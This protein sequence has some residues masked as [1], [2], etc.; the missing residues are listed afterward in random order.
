MSKIPFLII[1]LSGVLFLYPQLYGK[2]KAQELIIS[3]PQLTNQDSSGVQIEVN[4]L[5]PDKKYFVT[6]QKGSGQELIISG[7]RNET[8][9]SQGTISIHLCPSGL[10]GYLLQD[11]CDG[12]TFQENTYNVKAYESNLNGKRL[13][14]NSSFKVIVQIAGVIDFQN[15]SFK[16]TDDITI[17]VSGISDGSYNISVDGKDPNKGGAC[18]DA[19]NG[20][21]TTNIGKYYEGE[22]KIQVSTNPRSWIP[23]GCGAGSL[24][25]YRS[26]FINNSGLGGPGPGVG[27]G[28][29]FPGTDTIKQCK[30]RD[31][32]NFDKKND[33]VCALSGGESC[34]NNPTNPGFKTAIGCIH[35]NPA[36]LTKDLL[37]FLI[38]IGGGLAFLMMLFGAFQMITSG[39]NPETLAAGRS[40]LTSAI[41]GLLFVIFSILLLQIIGVGILNLPGFK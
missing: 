11:N 36:E 6:V 10:G 41:I 4:N 8:P 23:L 15:T 24:V 2:V 26:F 18:A 40:R 30:N 12:K 5:I 35:T 32:P 7:A 3:P 20:S 17:K 16:T 33:T 21:F 31:D 28:T 27:I 25:V 13:V 38:G 29:I 19:K 1:L 34:D 22:H 37:K 39:G 14:A 9:N